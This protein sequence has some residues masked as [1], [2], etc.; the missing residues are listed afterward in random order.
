M[1]AQ[2]S[3]KK[4]SMAWERVEFN[5]H[6]LSEASLTLLNVSDFPGIDPL[7]LRMDA[8]VW[9]RCYWRMIK[10]SSLMITQWTRRRNFSNFGVSFGRV[11]RG[12]SL[13]H[14]LTAFLIF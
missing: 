6:P 13:G 1:F 7:S 11:F 8:F 4:V 10:F 2:E 9:C 14:S 5:G 3:A 12:L